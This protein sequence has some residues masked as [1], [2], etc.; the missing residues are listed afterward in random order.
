MTIF[1][2]YIQR[3]M[4]IIAIFMTAICFTPK[5]FSQSNNNTSSSA[6]E[7]TIDLGPDSGV[8][9]TN[10]DGKAK[11]NLVQS[12][13]QI[14]ASLGNDP[15]SKTAIT[16]GKRTGKSF[17][18]SIP[19]DFISSFTLDKIRP[20]PGQIARTLN[21]YERIQPGANYL[22]IAHFYSSLHI[23]SLK[24]GP[25]FDRL[26][27]KTRLNRIAGGVLASVSRSAATLAVGIE[28]ANFTSTMWDSI[29]HGK[30]MAPFIELE[31]QAQ[32]ATTMANWT[33]ADITLT[34]VKKGLKNLKRPGLQTALSK[35]SLRVLQRLAPFAKNAKRV[36]TASKVL[37]VGSTA[38]LTLAEI[39]ATWFLARSYEPYIAPAA[40]AAAKKIREDSLQSTIKANSL[41]LQRSTEKPNQNSPLTTNIV[42]VA[43]MRE[44]LKSTAEPVLRQRVSTMMDAIQ[45]QKQLI[46]DFYHGKIF[47][48]GKGL[49]A[50]ATKIDQLEEFHQ[51]PLSSKIF[52]NPPSDLQ[53]LE[54]N[55]LKQMKEEYIETLQEKY[56]KKKIKRAEYLVGRILGLRAL[57]QTLGESDS[58]QK[59]ISDM[60]KELAEIDREATNYQI[61][62]YNDLLIQYEEETKKLESEVNE[63][64]H[65]QGDVYG[66]NEEG[67]KKSHEKFNLDINKPY[68]EQLTAIKKTL[69]N[70]NAHD[71]N[72][73]DLKVLE[74]I[75]L[76]YALEEFKDHP[77]LT[78][79]WELKQE[80]SEQ[81]YMLQVLTYD[82]D[83]RILRL[84]QLENEIDAIQLDQDHLGSQ[85]NSPC[86]QARQSH[87]VCQDVIGQR[88]LKHTQEIA[89]ALQNSVFQVTK[90]N[91]P[92]H[93]TQ[94]TESPPTLSNEEDEAMNDLLFGFAELSDSQEIAED[95]LDNQ[96]LEYGQTEKDSCSATDDSTMGSLK[97]IE[98]PFLN[99]EDPSS[100]V[101]KNR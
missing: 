30:E 36:Y 87:Q 48:T 67:V 64:V 7:V 40:L 100:G 53:F 21:A 92:T 63:W 31:N 2:E 68:H 71:L 95:C 49:L 99:Q 61:S 86:R 46:T 51:L 45:E 54:K 29:V 65:N 24:A 74:Q 50:M 22:P 19:G 8:E 94:K 43:S 79:E 11:K 17:L 70:F 27:E 47:S 10:K 83:A 90:N 55:I 32:L 80:I 81:E 84:V 12:R 69:A 38:I 77:E 20:T 62:T 60:E 78:K 96:E 26:I 18:F 101:L 25:V 23:S 59:M 73:Q 16:T 4:A 82:S 89:D 76:T 9:G 28:L 42:S 3:M 91:N 58:R 97:D 52:W 88:T 6:G 5:V 44:A 85:S 15:I 41:L 34:T 35:S 39:G 37:N 93:E 57:A 75:I 1:F 13:T 33:A 56:G 14:L 66:F 98:E 72:M